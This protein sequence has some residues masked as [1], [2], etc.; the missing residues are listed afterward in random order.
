MR[1]YVPMLYVPSGV[2]CLGKKEKSIQDHRE[3]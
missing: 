1:T 2:S 3:D